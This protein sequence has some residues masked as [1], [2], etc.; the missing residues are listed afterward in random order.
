MAV[1]PPLYLLCLVH[2]Y[3]LRPS[4]QRQ[5]Q[6]VVPKRSLGDDR[7]VGRRLRTD[8]TACHGGIWPN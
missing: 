6:G 7:A 3:L 1:V 4:Q 2:T 5:A 8:G